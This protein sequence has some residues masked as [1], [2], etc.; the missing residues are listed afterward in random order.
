MTNPKTWVD[1]TKLLSC[2]RP[3]DTPVSLGKRYFNSGYL[4]GSTPPTGKQIKTALREAIRAGT[5]IRF[6]PQIKLHTLDSQRTF[7]S[8]TFMLTEPDRFL[9][10]QLRRACYLT[11]R[12]ASG[13]WSV[14]MYVRP[15]L[16]HDY[17]LW[18]DEATDLHSEAYTA[19]GTIEAWMPDYLATLCKDSTEFREYV[20]TI[21]THPMPERRK[22][23]AVRAFRTP[24]DNRWVVAAVPVYCHWKREDPRIVNKDILEPSIASAQFVDDLKAV[25]QLARERDAIVKL[26]C[27]KFDSLSRYFRTAEEED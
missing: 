24:P 10:P 5:V 20:S 9:T 19:Q 13:D 11:W 1:P 4:S 23:L 18:L 15:G 6:Q 16:D 22:S 21:E 8:Q 26:I 3:F 14:E 7:G 2:V 17:L 25:Q 27:P 12:N